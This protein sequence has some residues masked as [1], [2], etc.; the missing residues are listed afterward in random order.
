MGKGFVH[1]LWL[2]LSFFP[3]AIFL[4]FPLRKF[5]L[6]RKTEKSQRTQRKVRYF[7][8]HPPNIFL[9]T[10][11]G[12][13][14]ITCR[15]CGKK[16]KKDLSNCPYCAEPTLQKKSDETTLENEVKARDSTIG[17]RSVFISILLYLPMLLF[18][19]ILRALWFV[20]SKG[21]WLNVNAWIFAAV[22][23]VVS[24]II[25][26]FVEKNKS[27]KQKIIDVQFEKDQT[28]ICPRCGSHSVSLGRK[29]YDWKKAFWCSVFN[30]EG[31]RYLAGMESRR[32][33]AHCNNCGHNWETDREWLD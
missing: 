20:L 21:Q 11:G 2:V 27:M 4:E 12:M 22:L 30:I 19:F 3:C 18:Q 7:Y 8:I 10:I 6:L 17:I 14:M 15:H 25:Y 33:T 5:I 32:I 16:Y 29:G 28:S 23:S 9:V 26:Y 13:I 31:G 1:R 24:G